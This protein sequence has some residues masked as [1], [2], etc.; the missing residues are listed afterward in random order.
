M[1]TGFCSPNLPQESWEAPVVHFLSSRFFAWAFGYCA[2][3]LPALE[4]SLVLSNMVALRFLV[5]FFFHLRG[6]SLLHVMMYLDV[7]QRLPISNCCFSLLTQTHPDI[8]SQLQ[9]CWSTADDTKSAIP[10]Y[11]SQLWQVQAVTQPWNWHFSKL[12]F[13]ECRFWSSNTSAMGFLRLCELQM[14]FML[15]QGG[16][17]TGSFLFS[18]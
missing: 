8:S 17:S 12:V 14:P 7:P 6:D 18:T 3:H 5:G 9:I 4:E 10:C 1:I 15:L 13:C 16:M 11:H 2:L